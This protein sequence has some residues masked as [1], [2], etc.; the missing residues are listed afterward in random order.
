MKSCYLNTFFIIVLN[1]IFFKGEAVEIQINHPPKGWECVQD[2]SQLPQKVQ[3]IYIGASAEK[4]ALNPSLNIAH[5]MTDSALSE[6]IALAK[7]YHEGYGNTR[8]A[9]LGKMKTAAG[10]VELMQ[11]DRPSQWGDVRFLQAML[12]HNGEAFVITA[13]CLKKEFG[14]LS[15]H[16]FRA[17]QS[18][19]F[20]ANCKTTGHCENR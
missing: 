12:I 9:L 13:T 18:I 16:L 15:S 3:V 14:S 10:E 1:L 17:I 19:S 20:R 7:T 2:P 6:Y 8:C 4:N 5:E 11:I